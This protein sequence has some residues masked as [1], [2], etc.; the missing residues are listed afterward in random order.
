MLALLLRRGGFSLRSLLLVSAC[1]FF[2][3]RAIPDSPARIVLGQDATEEQLARF[4]H[5]NGL[6][7]PVLAQFATWV[8]GIATRGDLGRSYV[9]GR[10]VGGEIARTLP[11]T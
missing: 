4:E 7:R 3:T 5:D 8:T 9:T 11:I 6:D 1:L 2:L 10:P